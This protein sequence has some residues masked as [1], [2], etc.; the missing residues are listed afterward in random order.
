M[1]FLKLGIVSLVSLSLLVT[2]LSCSRPAVT[3]TSILR[4]AAVQRGDITLSITGTGNLAYSKTE[5]LA[6][7]IAGY[8]EEVF[9][10]KGDTVKEG[11]DI[12]RL[13]TSD[14]ETEIKNLTSALNRVQRNLTTV[15]GKVTRARRSLVSAQTAV[16]KAQR[17]VAARELSVQSAELDLET[18]EYGLKD[19]SAIKDIADKAESVKNRLDLYTALYDGGDYSVSAGQLSAL[20]AEYDA[21][22]AKIENMKKGADA[23]VSDSEA[24]QI[25]KYMLR[26]EQSRRSVESARIAVEEAVESVADA[27]LDEEKAQK[28]VDDALIDLAEAEQGI[29]DAQSDLDKKK[30]LSPVVRAPFDGYITDVKI[31]GGDEVKKGSIAAVIADPEQFEAQILVTENDIFSVKVGGEA[32]VS[33]DALSDLAY[34]AKI[35]FVSPTARIT[36]GVVNYYVT[37]ELTS[38]KPLSRVFATRQFPAGAGFGAG[39]T[40]GGMPSGTPVSG[41]TASRG[42]LPGG[43][44]GTPPAGGG[45]FQGTPPAGLQEGMRGNF[46]VPGGAAAA[47]ASPVTVS[48]KQG[49]SATV[50][51]TTDQVSGVLVLPSRAITTKNQV[52]TVQ[53][54]NGDSTETRVV[55]VGMSDGTTTEIYSGLSEG[56]QVSFKVNTSTA[57]RQGSVA[58]GM[59]GAGQVMRIR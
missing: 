23:S 31:S 50:N 19:I 45:R 20:Q 11:D 25:A 16:T 58:I 24:L 34:P 47:E 10:G 49:M 9:V 51:I 59:G 53:V 35:V 37:V 46:R 54:V 33:L 1:K 30:S 41:E 15:K 7:E 8:V 29:I 13:N 4:T 38:L 56:E 21:A 32:V 12:A 55:T 5:E 39:G 2:S 44:Q 48:L 17:S 26:I 40:F 14:W 3:D 28:T 18:L 42:T 6:F 57:T 22:L 36:S 52:K 27:R 43:F